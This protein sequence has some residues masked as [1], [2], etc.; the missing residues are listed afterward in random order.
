MNEK[1]AKE[2][3]RMLKEFFHGLE[4][5]QRQSHD[6]AH[7]DGNAVFKTLQRRF[8]LF[9]SATALLVLL[10]GFIRIVRELK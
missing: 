7:L 3:K 8:K 2:N 9:V 5:P 4:Q 1:A 10:E 6:H